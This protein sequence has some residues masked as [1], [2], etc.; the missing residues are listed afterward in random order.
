LATTK[1]LGSAGFTG[2]VDKAS[3]F[4][5][6]MM[7][8]IIKIGGEVKSYLTPAIS[9]LADQIAG[10]LW[11]AVK[12]VANSEFAKWFGTTVVVAVNAAI[13]A[14]AYG[15]TI[16]SNFVTQMMSMKS[17]LI[18]VVAAFTAYKVATVAYNVVGAITASML[19]LQASRTFILNGAIVM[20]EAV[21]LR[22]VIAQKAMNLAMAANPILLV[23][24]LVAGLIAAYV[25]VITT[26]DNNK[27]AQDRLN[28]AHQATVVAADAAKAAED[29]LS[30]ANLSA[31]GAALQVEQA[32]RAYNDALAQFGPESLEARQANYNLEVAIDGKRRADNDAK[33]A[34][35]ERD[36]AQQISNTKVKEETVAAEAVKAKAIGGV[37]QEVLNQRTGLNLLTGE[38]GS[39]NGKTYKYSVVGHYTT[40]EEKLAATGSGVPFKLPGQRYI[41]GPVKRNQPYFVGENPD[42]SLNRTSELFVPNASGRIISSRE[43][44]QVMSTGTDGG[45]NQ[46]AP[47]SVS[48]S[49]NGTVNNVYNISLPNVTEPA[50]F[51]REFRLATLGRTN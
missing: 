20:G 28:A 36:K 25:S 35:E 48:G 29:R 34:Q 14:L 50:D 9:F 45:V 19:S 43:L 21:T 3:K 5:L 31:K 12:T 1:L 51:A 27:A 22:A 2:A 49:N 32:Q 41:G 13:Y 47:V 6:E 15:I 8:T 17:V 42:G 26:T 23:I 37:T 33:S 40:Y 39:L 7:N 18:G 10:P 11:T 4:G 38:L 30:G 44:R 16:V 46:A 24:G